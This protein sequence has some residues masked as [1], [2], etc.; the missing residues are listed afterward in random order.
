MD[1][2]TLRSH[3]QE[4]LAIAHKYGASNI[5]VFG[6][7]ARGEAGPLSDI[8]FLCDIEKGK[9]LLDIAKLKISLEDLLESKVDLVEYVAIKPSLKPLI[10]K[11]IVPL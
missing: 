9:S 11:D 10:E 4:I 8:D 3:K 7:V 2:E 5:S 1:L 6:S